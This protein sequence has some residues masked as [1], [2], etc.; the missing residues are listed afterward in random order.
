MNVC[1]L[2]MVKPICF[3]RTTKVSVHQWAVYWKW[4]YLNH[5]YFIILYY[6]LY[7]LLLI[8]DNSFFCMIF[9]KIRKKIIIN[10]K[11]CVPFSPY[12]RFWQSCLN[13]TNPEL[14]YR[15]LHTALYISTFN[16][17]GKAGLILRNTNSCSGYAIKAILHGTD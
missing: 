8:I 3:K 12:R 5:W 2:F 7:N 1:S 9:S 10:K 17:A 13:G 4:S 6:D 14:M 16:K 11:N 15:F